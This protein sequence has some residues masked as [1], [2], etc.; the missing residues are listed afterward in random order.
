MTPVDLSSRS[1]DWVKPQQF[2]IDLTMQEWMKSQGFR[3][4]YMEV[5]P[6]HGRMVPLVLP[7][8]FDFFDRHRKK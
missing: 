4:E 5:E 8:V 6:D 1:S 7:A 2:A 3:L